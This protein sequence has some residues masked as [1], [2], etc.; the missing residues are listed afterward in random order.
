LS[1]IKKLASQTAWYGFSNI[2]SRMLNYLLTPLLTS[3][4]AAGDFSKISTLFAM[5][6]FM[7]IIFSFGM[8][9]TYFRFLNEEQEQK[10]FNT[11]FTTILLSTLIFSLLGWFSAL[12]IA[13]MIQLQDHPQYV[14]W[15]ILIV[16]FDTLSVLPFAKLRHKGR[17]HKYAF[18]KISN[19]LLQIGL[20]YFILVICKN[21][22]PASFWYQWYRPE[23][24][25]GYVI[26]VN[27]F[28][29]ALTF[30]LLTGE[31]FSY[32][33]ETDRIFWKKTLIYALPLLIVGFGGMINEMIDR[34]MLLNYYP[35]TI[36]E[37]HQANGI[38]SANYK[39][40]V[41]IVLFIQAFRLG[42]EP[43]FFK[44]AAQK[45]A[46]LVYARVMK[47]FVIVCCFSFLGVVLF[48]DL[49]KY[50]M[51]STH[52]EYWS[53]LVIV[54]LLMVSKIFLGIYYNLSVWYKLT[55]KNLM[56]A[57]ITIGGAIITVSLNYFLIPYW[58]YTAC[59][60]A[61]MVC[62]G[63]MMVSSYYL[64]QKYFPVPY[65]VKRLLGYILLAVFIYFMY[66]YAV[67]GNI[68]IVPVKLLVGFLFA[69]IYAGM[70]FW[71]DK[72]EFRRLPLFSKWMTK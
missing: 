46:P 63:S 6:A 62:Y 36:P 27:V 52:K 3:L 14:Q 44:A 47:F 16:V 29:S 45:D 59:A 21:A 54:P 55:N 24:G 49:W 42:A 26:L 11:T 13:G 7:N 70:I 64:G 17:P 66:Q 38:Y 40:A 69:L 35:G 41:V 22:D 20:I 72:D 10:V 30:L 15:V 68:T 1:G 65:D 23:I 71:I 32:R 48:L 57:W 28:A 67:V 37:R 8:E 4:F 50:F 9:T 31:M 60:I 51:G 2:G 53:G 56:G 61:T 12:P 34:F 43:F 58:G 39:L 25:V 18:V 5:A 33:W 19:V